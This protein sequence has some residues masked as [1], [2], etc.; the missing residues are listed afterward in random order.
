[1]A[2]PAQQ[3]DPRFVQWQ[4]QNEWYISDKELREFADTVGM[5]YAQRNPGV[6]PEDVLNYV[7]KQVKQAFKD[8]F[9]NPN[10]NKPSTVE[11]NTS[12]N[13]KT[14]GS[15]ELTDEERKVMNTFVRQNVMTKEEYIEQV[16]AMRG[17]K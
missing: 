14:K 16:K 6:D 10:R 11:G 13:V 1:M 7:T 12:P 15:I 8:K 2:P 4:Q 3:I 17:L 5:G 9:V